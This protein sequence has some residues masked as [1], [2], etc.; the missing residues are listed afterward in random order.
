MGLWKDPSYLPIDAYRNYDADYANWDNEAAKVRRRTSARPCG[1]RHGE[2]RAERA[3][4]LDSRVGQH[5]WLIMIFIGARFCNLLGDA[6][7]LHLQPKKIYIKHACPF[8]PILAMPPATWWWTHAR[9][10][11]ELER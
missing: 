11:S 5:G 8:C 6:M 4:M 9:I 3:C 10:C 2:D 1:W 7:R